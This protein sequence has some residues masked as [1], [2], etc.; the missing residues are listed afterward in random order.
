METLPEFSRHLKDL[1]CCDGD[2]VTIQCEIKGFPEPIIFWE[3]DGVRLISGTDDFSMN[4][5]QNIAS[6]SINH[7]YHED[8][9]EYT[10]IAENNIGRAYSSACIIV[11]LKLTSFNIC[12]K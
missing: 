6:L 11:C 4:Y 10:C 8:E 2:K 3:K 7:I 9:G 12:N 1:R 5:N